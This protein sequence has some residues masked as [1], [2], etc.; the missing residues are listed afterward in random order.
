MA[1]EAN[2]YYPEVLSCERKLSPSDGKFFGCVWEARHSEKEEDTAVPLTLNEKTVRS[3]IS[4]YKNPADSNADAKEILKPNL[5]RLDSCM[6][7]SDKDTL[8]MEFTL[9]L[10]SGVERNCS[11]NMEAFDT[12]YRDWVRSCIDDDHILHELSLRYA[13]N[14]ANG[15]FLW[16]NRLG[17]DE[18][19]ITVDVP[20]M[21]RHFTFNGYDYSV[22]HFGS[23]ENTA[24]LQSLASLMEDVLSGDAEGNEKH[25]ILSVTTYAKV[26]KGQ[27]VF[28]SQEMVLDDGKTGR[29]K[30]EKRG[31]KSRYLYSV[32]GTA[33]MH[34]QKI[35]NAI[36]TID[37]W[38]DGSV[39][40]LPIAVE[41]YG[42]VTTR[43]VA[44]RNKRNDFYSLFKK[45]LVDGKELTETEKDFVIA[46][47][48]RG[49]VFGAK[50]S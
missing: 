10:F 12:R 40:A 20:T 9:K 48:L 1:K 50:E 49:G 33:A 28:P 39:A 26:G 36:R 44:H 25:V 34:S 21:D 3:T 30:E 17:A 7:P 41:S 38:Y 14:I 11:C 18:L 23:E 27:E 45:A 46:M 37:T 19:E 6:L 15:R 2:K 47:L 8:K 31:K 29:S 24:E 13:K 35:G 16:R 4:N 42:T 5:Q 32:F 22:N 43:S